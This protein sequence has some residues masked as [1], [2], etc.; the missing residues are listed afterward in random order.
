MTRYEKLEQQ[1]AGSREA[2]SFLT[3]A[4]QQK[5]VATE[6]EDKMTVVEPGS[7]IGWKEGVKLKSAAIRAS[8]L[9]HQ[10]LISRLRTAQITAVQGDISKEFNGLGA[11]NSGQLVK[12]AVGATGKF[13][14]SLT[15]GTSEEQQQEKEA[16]KRQM[17]LA[18]ISGATILVLLTY[19][20][21][22]R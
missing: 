5:A 9:T 3:K 18:L 19:I 21:F 11:T 15:G 22:F 13:L 8:D 16:K 2:L 14:T 12:G 20:L 6:V 7:E 1:G 4:M 17:P 10:D